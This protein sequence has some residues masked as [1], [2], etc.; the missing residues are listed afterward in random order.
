MF[1][2]PRAP[3]AQDDGGLRQFA[4]EA[5]AL[6][7]FQMDARKTA[8]TT[9]AELARQTLPALLDAAARGQTTVIER[10]GVPVAALVPVDA[11]PLRRPASILSLEGS[12]RGLWG[13]D[14]A[15]TIGRLRDEWDR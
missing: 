4:P 8:R 10:R 11:V 13:T 14:P 2:V 5:Y 1:A 15:S 12:G 6:Y 7:S 3:V 9:R